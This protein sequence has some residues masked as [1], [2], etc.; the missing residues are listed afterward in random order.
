LIG[1]FALA[2]APASHAIEFRV[3]VPAET[4]TVYISGN[5]DALGPWVPDALALIGDG[6]E[7]HVRLDVP[8]GK[9]LEYKFTLGSW[10]REVLTELGYLPPNHRL[11]ADRDQVVT[12]TIAAFKEDPEVYMA[13]WRGSG[14]VGTLVYWQDV[15][16]AFLGP[17]RNV[18]IWLP[19]GYDDDPER[20]YPVIYMHD[21][22]ELFD[23][24]IA[25]TG[26]DWGVDE[27][28][29]W[30]DAPRYARFLIEELMPRVNREFRTLTGPEHTFAM[31]SS[32]GGL[33]SYY[34][35][36]NHPDVFGACGCVSSHFALSEKAIADVTGIDPAAADATPYIVH[37]IENGATVPDGVRYYFDWGT[38][39]LDST[40][41][42]DHRP[43]RSWLLEQG[44]VE[45]EDFLM[46]GYEGH[47]HNEIAWRAR[48]IDQLVWLLAGS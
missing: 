32:M 31:G 24:R 33:L 20:R 22:Q 41:E 8:A 17:S 37:D 27:Y 48:V 44:L 46:R 40:Y 30:H 1:T 28:S 39:T 45:G 14:V 16:S 38:E 42:A 35:V 9:E 21:G 7:R 34:L 26:V 5:I 29:P 3:T 23:P 43:L 2:D 19:P 15:E 36:T 6:T 13:D 11:V 18:E 25:N 47:A 12:H 10:D 4:P